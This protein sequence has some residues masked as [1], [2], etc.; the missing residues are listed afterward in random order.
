MGK[1]LQKAL[2]WLAIAAVSTVSVGMVVALANGAGWWPG[3]KVEQGSAPVLDGSAGEGSEASPVLALALQ[4]PDQRAAALETLVTT[5]RSEDQPR[6]RYLRAIDLI[7]Q[8]NGGQALPL[9]ENLEEDYPVLAPLVGVKRGQALNASGQPDAAQKAWQSVAKTH[10]DTVAAGEALYQLGLGDPQY[11]D[12]LLETLPAHPRS[13]EVAYNRLVNTPDRA[14]G[15]EMGLILARYGIEHPELIS[16]LD[17][18]VERHGAQLTPEDWQAVG[19]AYWERQSYGAAGKAY[20]QAPATPQNRY[21]AARG[22]QIGQNRTVAIARY[23]QLMAEFPEAPETAE[24]I[25]KLANL[26]DNATALTLLDRVVANFPNRAAEAL[27]VK[28]AVLRDLGSGESAQK[29]TQSVLSQYSNSEAAAQLRLGYAHGAAEGGNWSGAMQWAQQ[30]L[31]ENPDSEE[32][33]EAGFWAGKWQL[34]AGQSDAAQASFNQVVKAYPESYYAWRS[35]VHLGW[36]VG[37]FETVRS[38]QPQVRLPSQRTA[39]PAGSETLQELY[40]LGQDQD[41]WTLWQMEFANRQDPTVEEQFTDGVMRLGVGDN[42]DGIYM[43]SS[44][45]WREPPEEQAVYATLKDHPAYGQTLYPFPYAPTIAQW[46][47]E[48]QLNPLLVIALIRQESRF[49]PKIRSGVGAT[50]LMQVMPDT[51]DWIQTQTN[52]TIKDLED[53]IDN[54]KLGTWYL[55]YTH[56]EY[57]NNSLYAVAS[58]NAGP[59]NVADWIDRRN[60]ADADEFVHRIPFNETRGYIHSVFG[61]YWNYLRLYNPEVAQRLSQL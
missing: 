23:G 27:V 2:P 22:T 26:V 28:S 42:L 12:Q 57:D 11:W 59:G 56:G 38:R 49:E 6:A 18:L 54:I 41:A 16:Q 10:G 20:S 34:R 43:I 58:Y 31:K 46:S 60:Y 7:N 19:F 52:I 17:Q 33:P 61:G 4:H 9:L 50:G 15:K 5:Q 37:D 30:L 35:A 24:G 21:R 13:V 3:A 47:A 36:D 25:L 8:G 14:D 55:D 39:L 44:L 29:A 32:A 53:P 40:R 45:A 1:R 48:R 51:A